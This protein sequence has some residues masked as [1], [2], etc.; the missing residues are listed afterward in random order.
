[1]VLQRRV[2]ARLWGWSE[3]GD[4][5]TITVGS[6]EV[7]TAVADSVSGAWEVNLPAR[8]ANSSGTT[9]GIQSSDQ[10]THILLTDILFGDVLLCSG[11]SNME[12]PTIFVD[13]GEV[14]EL[15]SR[16][17]DFTLIRLLVVERNPFNHGPDIGVLVP[18][19]LPSPSSLVGSQ[20]V[21][22][23]NWFSALCWAT[24]RARHES[25]NLPLGL[26]QADAGSTPIQAW[27]PPD[28]AVACRRPAPWTDDFDYWG[29]RLPPSSFFDSIIKP[30]APMRLAAVVWYHG[31]SN[32]P[33]PG[34]EEEEAAY[35]RCALATMVSAWRLLWA[36]EW[37]LVTIQLHAMRRRHYSPTGFALLRQAQHDSSAALSN[38]HMVTAIDLGDPGDDLHPK[39][40]LQL[41]QRITWSLEGLLSSTL[42]A[43]ETSGPVAVGAQFRSGRI[44][45]HF[46][47]ATVGSDGI[48]LSPAPA[49]PVE[50]SDCVG[51][52]L[53]ALE[54][55]VVQV[56]P[57]RTQH[58]STV[59][60][61][62]VMAQEAATERMQESEGGDRLFVQYCWGPWPLA[63]I[64]NEA[65]LP[66]PPFRFPVAASRSAALHT[67]L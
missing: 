51:L 49:C 14:D 6:H 28:A 39:Y 35:Y 60:A 48:V 21:P 65:G 42:L 61:T 54:G 33:L 13:R 37:G 53:V 31:E 32:L 1:M 43:H 11:Q 16:L 19:S 5:I 30:L 2:P 20:T 23:G 4:T 18:W 58:V 27:L 3:P 66:A 59:G 29:T 45:I 17:E 9:V 7:H 57:V 22:F 10:N 25:N 24:G 63:T 44:I 38:T 46:A 41:A 36:Q 26:I 40:K 15:L 62:L 55:G 47:P 64:F 8:E 67:D 50:A 56:H 12:L 52:Q 34:A